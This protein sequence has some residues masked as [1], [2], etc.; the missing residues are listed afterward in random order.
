[1]QEFN[2]TF[3]VHQTDQYSIIL[4]YKHKR[5]IKEIYCVMQSVKC[6]VC[7]AV[8]HDTDIHKYGKKFLPLASKELFKHFMLSSLLQE[9]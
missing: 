7:H 1:M 4:L 2:T 9:M 3:L 6:Q 5:D 8:V